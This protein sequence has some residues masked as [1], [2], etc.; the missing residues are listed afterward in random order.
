[1]GFKVLTMDYKK[2]PNIG[3]FI[4]LHK[5][6]AL[7]PK[8]TP[9]QEKE[10]IKEVL[11]VSTYEARIYDSDLLGTFLLGYKDYLFIPKNFKLNLEKEFFKDFDIEFYEIDTNKTALSNDIAII[12]DKIIVHNSLKDLGKIIED[13]TGFELIT[14]SEKNYNTFGSYLIA[15]DYGLLMNPYLDEKVKEEIKEI[16]K[17]KLKINEGTVNDNSWILGSG[18]LVNNNGCLVG[19][20]TRGDEILIINETFNPEL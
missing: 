15:N 19:H 3:A 20:L 9:K 6:F 17:N 4:F 13:I 8:K 10:K 12:K 11:K 14:F 16:F 2:N 7:V 18:I 1:M 5:D